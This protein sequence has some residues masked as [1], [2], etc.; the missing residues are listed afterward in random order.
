MVGLTSLLE[1]AIQKEIVMGLVIAL[2]N[3]DDT[4]NEARLISDKSRG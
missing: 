1:M 4:A 3:R 2:E